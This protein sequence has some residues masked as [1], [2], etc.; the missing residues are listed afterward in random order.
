MV[1]QIKARESDISRYFEILHELFFGKEAALVKYAKLRRVIYEIGLYRYKGYRLKDIDASSKNYFTKRFL[2][3]SITKA[4]SED[5]DRA[6]TKLKVAARAGCYRR[7]MCLVQEMNQILECYGLRKLQYPETFLDYFTIAC[8][9]AKD[10]FGDPVYEEPGREPSLVY[11][12]KEH[13][14]EFKLVLK[15]I[16]REGL[17][18][19]MITV[20]QIVSLKRKG[21]KG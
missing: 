19:S 11:H 9:Q 14:E 20:G 21:V 10:E 5:F 15:E 18:L 17:M 7:C 6:Y 3:S 16:E 4:T 1:E 12:D 2:C 13:R 8:E